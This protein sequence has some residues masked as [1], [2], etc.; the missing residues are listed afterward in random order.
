M[1]FLLFSTLL[2]VV[3]AGCQT[4]KPLAEN[5]KS[6]SPVALVTEVKPAA[7]PTN[8]PS[9]V[10]TKELSL[11]DGKTLSGWAI[12]G[13]G[14]HGVVGVENGEI[15]IGMGADLSGINWTNGV[16]PKVNYEIEFDA[17]KVDGSDFFCGLTFPVRES[18]CSLILG[19]WGGGTVGLSSLDGMDASENDTSRSLYFERKRWFHIRLR[20]LEE[21][22]ETW[23]DDKKI[24][25]VETK[26]RKIALRPGDIER[27]IP[28]GFSTYQT[29]AAL[30][31]IKIRSV[32][33]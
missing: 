6:S 27:G 24:I 32:G 26:G 11:F 15:Q 7:K 1:K 8:A 20:V 19:G 16:L 25:D 30:K 18:Y 17:M 23:I 33:D 22:I 29:T 10:L 9:I 4:E 12:T 21:K 5:V 2:P 31:T 13:F 3:W 28:L 14:G